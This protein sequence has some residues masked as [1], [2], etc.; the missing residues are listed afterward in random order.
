MSLTRCVTFQLYP[1]PA[2]EKKLF[3]SLFF[4]CG[5]RNFEKKVS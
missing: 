4:K 2:Q 3:E 1:K 5:E